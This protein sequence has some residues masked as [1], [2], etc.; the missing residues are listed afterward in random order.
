M[1]QDS[2]I[3]LF[4]TT[5]TQSLLSVKPQSQIGQFPSPETLG[6]MGTSFWRRDFW[7]SLGGRALVMIGRWWYSRRPLTNHTYDPRNHCAGSLYPFLYSFHSH[8]RELS[9]IV[10]VLFYSQVDFRG[11]FLER[12]GN[13]S[14]TKANFE[15]KTCWIV[16]QFLAH[17]PVNFAS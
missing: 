8:S 1:T 12:P 3:V 14:G 7:D 2:P 10:V 17:K 4:S 15:I 16:A 6:R 5:S 9:C 13:F 11:S